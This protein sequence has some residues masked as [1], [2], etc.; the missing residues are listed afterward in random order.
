MIDEGF[1]SNDD[2]RGLDHCTRMLV[3]RGRTENLCTG[4]GGS[5]D[6]MKFSKL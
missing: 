5:V 2:G 3:L 6:G 4:P 1:L